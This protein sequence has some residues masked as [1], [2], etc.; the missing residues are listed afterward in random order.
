M[1]RWFAF[2]L[3][4]SVALTA[5][6]PATQVRAQEENPLVTEGAELYDELRFEE[7]LQVLSAAL[8]RAGNSEAEQQTLYRLLAYTYL[9]LGRDAEAEGAYR[10]LLVLQP[11]FEVTDASPRFRQFFAGAKE[12]WET[13]GRPGISVAPPAP[14]TIEHTS[15]PQGE[16]ETEVALEAQIV[17]PDGRVDHLVLAYR[18]GTSDVF[19]RVDATPGDGGWSV[20]IPGE[21]VR[22]PL[23]EYYFEA[24]DGGGLPVASRGDIAAPLRIAVEAEAGSS[25]LTKWWFWTAAA[26]VV[27]GAVTATV[28]LTRGDDAPAQGTLV[29]DVT[30]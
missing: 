17:D 22:P 29:I 5:L 12:R 14:V 27:G 20:V 3:M 2:A 15:P 7:A 23:V 11:D 16:R 18:Q 6:G 4:F 19:R 30:D 28:L 1:K 10:R 21:D 24:I 9:A 8:I 25:I 26:V 13:E